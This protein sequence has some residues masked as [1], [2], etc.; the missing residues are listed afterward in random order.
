MP[1]LPV[2]KP[3]AAS[4]AH[5]PADS[6]QRR[7]AGQ[8]APA[9]LPLVGLNRFDVTMAK[10]AAASAAHWPADPAQRRPAAQRRATTRLRDLA[11]LSV[12]LAA[13]ILPRFA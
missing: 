12:A 4:A 5:W 11:F 7:P 3:A 10:P 13:L 8:A 1:G 9:A 2:A 6:A